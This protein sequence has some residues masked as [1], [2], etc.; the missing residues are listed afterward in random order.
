LLVQD[1]EGT[2]QWVVWWRGDRY[3]TPIGKFDIAYR[4]R[5]RLVNRWRNE[6]DVE[7]TWVDHRVRK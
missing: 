5:T 4:V 7:V 1:P 6:H 3:E 2:T